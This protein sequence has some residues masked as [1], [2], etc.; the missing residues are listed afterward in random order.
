MA[1][2]PEDYRQALRRFASGITVVTVTNGSE[3]HGMTASSFAA[4]SL[5][6]PMVLVSL[7]KGSHTRSLVM[8]SRKFA[9][10]VLADNQE[11]VARA[12]SLAG[13]KPFED[14]KF[15][16]GQNGAPLLEGALA[17]IECDI[18]TTV[19]AG[20]HDVVIANVDHCEARDGSPLVY[21]NRNYRSLLN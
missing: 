4:V 7:E 19:D 11:E 6:P 9:V 5:T 21:F 16:P 3:L 15:K 2:G 12:F 17:W 20:D 10:N 8:S 1:V 13:H 14:L 18:H